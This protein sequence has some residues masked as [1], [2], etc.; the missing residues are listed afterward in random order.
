MKAPAQSA[1]SAHI[2]DFSVFAA[3]VYKTKSIVSSVC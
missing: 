3:K 2:M 1:G